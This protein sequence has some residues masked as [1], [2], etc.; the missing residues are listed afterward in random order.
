MEKYS[1]IKNMK[2]EKPKLLVVDDEQ[3]Q[4]DSIKT[5]FAR[6]NFLVFVAPSGE[7]ALGSIQK[8]KPDLVLLDMK[9]S[10]SMDGRDVLRDLRKYDKET[11]V[12]IITGN[13]L[14]EEELREITRLGI[15]EFL[16]KPV[17]VRTLDEVVKRILKESYP[18]TIRFEALQQKEEETTDVSLRRL[19]HELSN[20]TGDITNKCELYILDTE[21]GLY[22]GKTEKER[23]EKAIDVIK[24]VFKSTERLTELVKKLS[25]LAKKER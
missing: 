11:K 7:E 16:T 5:Y 15:V 2:E 19:S 14:R 3:S 21:E 24:S 1:I 8:H 25:S 4:V 13:I 10:G 22:K 17:N 6:R 12:V 20:I 9:L 23:L 18:K